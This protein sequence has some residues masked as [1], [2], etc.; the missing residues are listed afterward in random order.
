MYSRCICPTKLPEWVQGMDAVRLL[1][2]WRFLIYDVDFL[3]LFVIVY[4][5]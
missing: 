5:C 2:G 1:N 3:M 4:V